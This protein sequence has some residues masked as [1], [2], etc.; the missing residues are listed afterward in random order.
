[1][2]NF[3]KLGIE[4][5]TIPLPFRLNHVNCFIAEGENGYTIIDAGLHDKAAIQAWEPVVKERNIADIIITHIH[6]DHSGY[7]GALQEKTGANVSM[8]EVD[9]NAY[10]QIW[11]PSAPPKLQRDYELAAVPEDI[12][13]GIIDITKNFSPQILPR[14]KV[15]HFLQEG[16][17]IQFGT[18]EYEVLFTPGH[19]EGL[20]VLYNKN[21]NVLLS[22]DHILP[23]I[24]PNISYWFYGEPNPLQSFEHSLQK[25]KELNA[26]LV[27]PSHGKP[28]YDA[29]QRIDEIWE[30]HLE[31][32]DMT[33]EAIKGGATVFE[34]CDILFPF[35]LNTYDYQF[36]I[37]EAIAHLEYLRG[38]NKC[39][40]TV[41]QGVWV[42]E[43]A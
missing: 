13:K 24:T 43:Q 17:M 23:R 29:N 26:D 6:P 5:M 1:M 42:Y 22:T 7:A 25:I 15:N 20:I 38:K 35:E 33:L 21:D 8:T 10:E 19:S 31:R 37:G 2:E 3:K 28:F 9:A 30:H 39:T 14:P 11:T 34:V 40:R 18:G 4:M 16:E 32:F 36:A 41:H 12:S 27:I